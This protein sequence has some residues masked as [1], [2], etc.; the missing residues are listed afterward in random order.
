M[1]LKGRVSS[2][3]AKKAKITTTN[4]SGPS[5]VTVEVPAQSGTITSV[6]QLNALN[7]VTINNTFAGSVL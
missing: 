4:S 1:A 7:D 5:Q 6:S 2:T 3:N